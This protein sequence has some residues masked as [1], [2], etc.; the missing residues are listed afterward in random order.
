MDFQALQEFLV[1]QVGPSKEILEILVHKALK[2][3]LENLEKW[4]IEVPQAVVLKL[5]T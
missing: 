4:V 5:K 2:V 1:H 3:T